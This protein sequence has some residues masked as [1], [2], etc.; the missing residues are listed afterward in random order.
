MAAWVVALYKGDCGQEC[1]ALGGHE[2]SIAKRP[3]V[4]MAANGSQWQPFTIVGCPR[5][6]LERRRPADLSHTSR[7][8]AHP[9]AYELPLCLPAARATGEV[10]RFDPATEWF[11]IKYEDSDG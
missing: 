3:I 11:N 10:M 7:H 8:S 6:Q 2:G 9:I 5:G 4:P 1:R